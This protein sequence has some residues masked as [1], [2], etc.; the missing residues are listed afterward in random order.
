[1]NSKQ[2]GLT[3]YIIESTHKTLLLGFAIVFI[4]L[5]TA[6]AWFFRENL[7]TKHQNVLSS[8][9]KVSQQYYFSG[10]IVSMR[11]YL[12]TM[13]NQFNFS[14]SLLDQN[15]Q[16]LWDLNSA[17]VLQKGS[18]FSQSSVESS[19]SMELVLEWNIKKEVIQH[20]RDFG[21]AF[22]M[23]LVFSF[24]LLRIQNKVLYTQ[25]AGLKSFKEKLKTQAATINFSLPPD[26]EDELADVQSWFQLIGVQWVLATKKAETIARQTAFSELA[27]QVSHDIK[28]PLSALNMLIGQ[29]TQI[30]ENH[31]L[32]MR[33]A[34]QRINDIANQL[35]HKSKQIVSPEINS[36]KVKENE[37]DLV[38][39]ELLSPIIDSLISEKRVQY[40]EL[41]GVE[42]EADI[43]K[44]YGLFVN[45]SSSEFKR[46][47]SNLINNAVEALENGKGKVS[48][49]IYSEEMKVIVLAK[50]N[51]KGIPDHII[52]KLGQLGVTYG[53]EGTDS[54]SG[55]GV[56][57][58]KKTIE[59]FGGEFEVLSQPG[60]GTTVTIRFPRAAAPNWFVEKLSVPSNSKIVSI[61]DD[62]SI[63]HVWKERF[64]VVNLSGIRTEHLTY[65]SVSEFKDSVKKD[66]LKHTRL[67]LC[68]YEF[69]EQNIS[70]LDIIETLSI[71][72]QS[73]LVTSRY[74]E[75][76]VR[77]RCEE[78]GVRLI[79]KAMAGFVPIETINSKQVFDAILIDDDKE[80]IHLIWDQSAKFAGKKFKAYTHPNQFISDVKFIDFNTPIYIDSNLGNG[81][82]GEE[83]AKHIFEMGFKSIY[84]S[85]GYK[86][87]SY[88]P[89]YWIKEI[90]GKDPIFK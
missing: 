54:G 87:S 70:G 58:A 1:M 49:L 27:A 77:Q 48:V 7:K 19:R 76:K 62:L 43:S 45:I 15:Q 73:I 2:R 50:D 67:Y 23:F 42:I 57:H 40:R 52:E 39:V 16:V 90:V 56:Y 10:D 21:A 38:K 75:L 85:T 78:L 59:S 37:N 20:Y 89:M 30:P 9:L 12:N 6:D 33:S 14:G 83:V 60:C 25:L 86:P 26:T 13:A 69:L 64:K 8:L 65:T 36:S 47:L 61:D 79:P 28:S 63:H 17:A 34:I 29:M 55:L 32:V 24:S 71:G 46:I 11:N 41:Q 88:S 68:D 66:K 80:L 51:G 44:G 5:T 31:R 72:K 74:E 35:L 4:L 3:D 82:K 18:I 22:L 84:L 81:I 53:K